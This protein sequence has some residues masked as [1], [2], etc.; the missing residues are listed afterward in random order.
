[1]SG[2]VFFQQ[3]TTST[4]DRL[5]IVSLSNI[6]LPASTAP[7]RWH[8]VN[9]TGARGTLA[10]TSAGA[11]SLSF[12]AN[13]AFGA[14]SAGA[15]LKLEINT[16]S[17]R[18]EVSGPFGSVV[19]DPG[20]YFQVVLSDLTISFPGIEIEGDFA[21]RSATRPDGSTVQIIAGNNLRVFIGDNTGGNRVGLEMQDGLALFIQ[22]GTQERGTI[23]GTVELVGVDGITL[24]ARLTVRLNEGTFVGTDTFELDGETITQTFTSLETGSFIQVVGTGVQVSVGGVAELRGNFTF[25]RPNTRASWW[26]APTCRRSSAKGPTGSTTAR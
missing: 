23:T 21:F 25:T 5:V 10:L 16:T 18:I 22:S 7:A 14:F 15:T 3:S 1:M 8:P 20:P 9:I 6:S 13:V 4:G 19:L 17:Q 11:G 26:P 12:T 2:N 24:R